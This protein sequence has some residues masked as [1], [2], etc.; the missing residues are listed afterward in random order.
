MTTAEHVDAVAAYGFSDHQARF[1][2]LVMRH[3]G[4]CIKRQYAEFA[5]VANGGEKCNAFFEKLVRRGFA[6]ATDCI[7]SACIC[8]TSTRSRSTTGSA[9]WTAAIDAGSRRGTPPSA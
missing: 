4:L 9:T 6:A 3:S 2:I 5:G 7:H 1:L 8:T